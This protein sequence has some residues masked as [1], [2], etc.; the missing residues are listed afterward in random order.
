MYSIVIT[1]SSLIDTIDERN[2]GFVMAW[3]W[4]GTANTELIFAE[5][6]AKQMDTSLPIPT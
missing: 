3:L 1:S 2:A 6:R 5:K 4:G